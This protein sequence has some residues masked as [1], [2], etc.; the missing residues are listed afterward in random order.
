MELTPRRSLHPSACRLV[1][2]IVP[3]ERWRA[4]RFRRLQQRFGRLNARKISR[5]RVARIGASGPHCGS[6]CCCSCA[7]RRARRAAVVVRAEQ[8]GD[9]DWDAAWR[10]CEELRACWTCSQRVPA[11][12]RASS[13]ELGQQSRSRASAAECW[14]WTYLPGGGAWPDARRPPPPSL[15]S[16][17]RAGSRQRCAARWRPRSPPH[18]PR[19]PSRRSGRCRRV[20]PPPPRS[21]SASRC[22]GRPLPAAE[23]RRGRRRDARTR[24]LT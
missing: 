9:N 10:R 18:P 22:A 19:A 12:R 24:T 14:P 21:S 2:R 6:P 13:R 16:H 8:R 20:P 11:A 1:P 5:S 15:P 7:Q 17:P 23:A 3:G 4:Q